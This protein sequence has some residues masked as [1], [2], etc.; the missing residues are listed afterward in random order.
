MPDF[1]PDKERHV[2]H[3]FVVQTAWPGVANK[4]KTSKGELE[5]NDK[6]R[7]IIKDEVLAREIQKEH[8]HD[9]AV[10]RMR[11]PKPA[12]QGHRYFFGQTKPLP[13][14]KYDELGRRIQEEQDNGDSDERT[15]NS[16]GSGNGSGTGS[17]SCQRPADGEGV[18]SEHE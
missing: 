12:D 5:M 13:W 16:D 11:M 3:K 15:E 1:N 17:G 6:G 7:M 10:T 18:T 14:A 8:P 9:L 4:V 2:D